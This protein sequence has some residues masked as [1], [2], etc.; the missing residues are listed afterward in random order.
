MNVKNSNIGVTILKI[1]VNIVEPDLEIIFENPNIPNSELH[2]QFQ[3]LYLAS[4]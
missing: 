1:L 4:K 3:S 2:P